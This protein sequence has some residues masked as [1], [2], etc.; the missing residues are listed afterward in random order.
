MERQIASDI[1]NR[2]QSANLN[3]LAL[4]SGTRDPRTDN[5]E[6]N[7][8]ALHALCLTMLNLNEFVYVD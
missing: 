4:E 5:I 2:Q 1:L 3:L 8:R 6:S 7:R